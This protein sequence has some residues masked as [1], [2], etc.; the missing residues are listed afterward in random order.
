MVI[1][2]AI[3]KPRGK[4]F[5]AAFYPLIL[6][7]ILAWAGILAGV[8][9]AAP[10]PREALP[11]ARN[12]ASEAQDAARHGIPLVVLYTQ[13]GCSWC[14]RVRREYLI[15]M[16]RSPQAHYLYSWLPEPAVYVP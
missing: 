9:Q 4:S 12:L 6:R 2:E 8:A 5:P 14:E 7:W 3:G 13:T 11:A 1:N 15:P 10:A 16:T